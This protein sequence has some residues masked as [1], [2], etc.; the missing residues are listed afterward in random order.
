MTPDRGRCHIELGTFDLPTPNDDRPAPGPTGSSM[1]IG[2]YVVTGELGRGGMGVVLR[3]HDP[4]LSRDVAIKTLL[5]VGGS[6]DRRERFER[7]ARAAARLRHPGI[8]GVHEVGEHAGRPYIVMDFVEGETLDALIERGRI[9]PRRTAELIRDVAAA[10]EHAHG[11]GILHRDVK[12]QNVLIDPGGSTHLADF[13]LAREL[14]A[15]GG[16]LTKTGQLVGTPQYVAPE[17]VRGGR[18]A[19]GVATD[20]YGIGGILYH[21]LVG[22]PAFEGETLLELLNK[23]L[24][25]DPESPRQLDPSIHPDLETIAL[26]CLEKDPARRYRRAGEVAAD[27]DRFLAGEAISARP[28]GRRERLVR[29]GRRNP[30]LAAA[31]GALLV[32]IL[33]GAIAGASFAAYSFAEI[34]EALEEAS[35][36]RDNAHIAESEAVA[37]AKKASALGADAADARDEALRHLAR[38]LVT[39]AASL[40]REHRDA[41][42]W[43]ALARSLELEDAFATR[44]ALCAARARSPRRRWATP[45]RLRCCA[46]D[47]AFRPGDGGV[48][49]ATSAGGVALWDVADGRRDERFA[50]QGVFR[51]GSLAWSPD[52]RSLATTELGAPIVKVWDLGTGADPRAIAIADRL[53]LHVRWS[54]D[55]ATLAVSGDDFAISLVDVATGETRAVIPSEIGSA[56]AG[57]RP[58]WRVFDFSPDG[59]L[60]ATAGGSERITVWETVTGR[61]RARL[62]RGGAAAPVAGLSWLADDEVVSAHIDGRVETGPVDPFGEVRRVATLDARA[63]AVAASPDGRRVA[64]GAVDGSV[65]LLDPTGEDAIVAELIGPSTAG[66]VFFVAWSPDGERVAAGDNDGTVRVWRRDDGG[67]FVAESALLG[68][69]GGKIRTVDVSPDGRR[70]VSTASHDATL[71]WDADTGRCLADLHGLFDTESDLAS[72][73]EPDGA[74]LLTIGRTGTFVRRDATTGAPR[75]PH[76]DGAGSA[77]RW[78]M[79]ARATA[80]AV[81]A[82]APVLAAALDDEAVAVTVQDGDAPRAH[83]VPVARAPRVVALSP[84]GGLLAVG[85]RRWILLWDVAA[86][87]TRAT[88]EHPGLVDALAFD[89]DGARLASGGA[90]RVVR[91]WSTTD[92]SS[93]KDLWRH[94]RSIGAL[95]FSPD[96][97]RIASGDGSG[98]VRIW[99]LR[100]R[101][102]HHDVNVAGRPVTAIAWGPDGSW[103]VVARGS[104]LR[105]WDLPERDDGDDGEM[106]SRHNGAVSSLAWSGDGHRLVSTGVYDRRVSVFEVRG[107]Q[108]LT[109]DVDEV[110]R[111]APSSENLR[112]AALDRTGARLFVSDQGATL[113]AFDVATRE[114]L[115][116]TVTTEGAVRELRVVPEAPPDRSPDLIAIRH[117]YDPTWGAPTLLRWRVSEGETTVLVEAGEPALGAYL[118]PSLDGLAWVG[119]DGGLHLGSAADGTRR[120]TRVRLQGAW[121]LAVLP[122]GERFVVGARSYASRARDEGVGVVSLRSLATGDTLWTRA[123]LDGFVASAALAPPADI[124]AVGT[125]AG[126]V[127]LFEVASGRPVGVREGNTSEVR[128]LAFSPDG[129]WFATG[130]EGGAV[131]VWDVSALRT[132]REELVAEALASTGLDVRGNEI[133]AGEADARLISIDALRDR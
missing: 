51:G 52:G 91:I 64:V 59:R 2:R 79:T 69:G 26:R 54:P 35:D 27:L 17:Q 65:R 41:E 113:R 57:A 121:A 3:A 82:R 83:L 43:I 58:E 123:G 129:R 128:R 125:S 40:A 72:R 45:G 6:P 34:R 38:S 47:L 39:N 9:P 10:I 32:V 14:D 116:P 42:A 99:G 94:D 12:P 18:D 75:E 73:W 37:Q 107:R 88:I 124:V 106:I 96:G 102:V 23:V 33:G 130:S 11:N 76:S 60:L 101:N 1:R 109:V 21:A 97:T 87:E 28:I 20:V 127:A 71:V 132:P 61:E 77:M 115:G 85:G 19:I 86:R 66:D 105:R 44:L 119:A 67:S 98:S 122:D 89:G 68:H 48:L 62:E 4:T 55:G 74:S 29:W 50:W 93:I 7:E 8:V 81:A 95:A 70:V 90:D 131:R 56:E 5:D 31:V 80:V 110:L 25:R 46:H 63:N 103:L 53:P 104:S 78:P 118:M 22:R 112:A 13:G 117:D 15:T 16:E 126:S 36:E 133:V 108:R 111:F 30:A 120:R 84:D 24:T 92:G 100:F 114:P 49:A